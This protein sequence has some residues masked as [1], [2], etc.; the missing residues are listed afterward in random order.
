MNVLLIG[1]D[2]VSSHHM[3]RVFPLTYEFLSRNGVCFTNFNKV[4]ENTFPNHLALFFGMTAEHILR[5]VKKFCH[6]KIKEN[7]LVFFIKYI[8]FLF[9]HM[10]KIIPLSC[11]A[12]SH[13]IDIAYKSFKVLLSRDRLKNFCHSP[14]QILLCDLIG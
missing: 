8:V 12:Q 5:G 6:K 1:L 2:S 3:R 10:F 4:A 14:V 11:Y 7:F 9:K 13:S